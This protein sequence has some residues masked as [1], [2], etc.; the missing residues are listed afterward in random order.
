M[1]LVRDPPHHHFSALLWD[2]LCDPSRMTDLPPTIPPHGTRSGG[3]RWPRMPRPNWTPPSGKQLLS[4]GGKQLLRAVT[5]RWAWPATWRTRPPKPPRRSP[6]ARWRTRSTKPP[7]ALPP[8]SQ[9]PQ[10]DA[11]PQSASPSQR[12]FALRPGPS[13]WIGLFVLLLLG[14]LGAVSGGV[15]A[16]LW[17]MSLVAFGTGLFG[18]IRKRRTL[19]FGTVTGDGVAALLVGS[20]VMGTAGI[21]F[22]ATTSPPKPQ[23]TIV[24][25]SSASPSQPMPTP[26]PS[27]SETPTPTPTP[28]DTP[29]PTPMPSA[30]ASTEAPPG[31]VPAPATTAA[32][33]AA[34]IPAPPPPA[35][36]G[37]QYVTKAVHAGAYCSGYEQGWYGYTAAHVRM[38]C[39]STAGDARL[40]WRA[41]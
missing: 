3:W 22:A 33:P 12:M 28:A 34:P 23:P 2:E 4:A 30:P 11:L 13:F 17:F 35:P 29:T 24:V 18:W 14:L 39:T 6:L 5:P 26:T 40:R 20:L 7:Q 32:P 16:A 37:P 9:G 19:W 8:G 15:G 38:R 31:P 36:Q 25:A 1:L 27:A 21:A 10:I 41:A